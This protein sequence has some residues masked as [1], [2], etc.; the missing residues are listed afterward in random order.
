[1]AMSFV[2]KKSRL[3]EQ[4]LWWR[5]IMLLKDR[6]HRKLIVNFM[7]P[8]INGLRRVGSKVKLKWQQEE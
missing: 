2:R 1:M 8:K 5:P 4:T 7:W 6:K 3:R